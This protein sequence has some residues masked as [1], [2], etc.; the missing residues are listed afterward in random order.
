MKITRIEIENFRSI[1]KYDFLVKDF[2]VFVGQNNHGKT[3]LFDALDWFDSGKTDRANYRNHDAT[4]PIKVRVHFSQV[5][6]TLL[7]L[8]EGAYRTAIQ[9]VLH[10]HDSLIVEKTS[11][12]DKRALIIN[13]N[14]ITNPRGFDSALNYFLPKIVYV[15]TKHRLSDVASY[16][17]KS[18]IAEMLGDVL[19]DMVDHEPKYRDFLDLFN[20]LFNTST[21][22]FRKSVNDLQRRV[23]FYLSKQFAE[24][25]TVTFRIENPEVEDM[26]KKFET[27]VDDGVKTKAEEKGDGMQRAIMLAIVQAYADYRKEKGIARNFVFLIDEAELHLH[28][29]AQRSLKKALRDIVDNGG[30]VFINSHSSIFANEIFE[31]QKIF[32]VEKRAGVS[33]VSEIEGKQEQLDSIYQ[34]LGGSPSDILLPSNF[35]IVEG[36]SDYEFLKRIIMRFYGTNNKCQQIK[37]LFA[38][39]DIEREGELYH[40][41]HETY[42]PLLTNGIYKNKVVFLLD[43]PHPS[44]KTQY[45]E[46]K[47]SHPYLVEGEQIQILPVSALEMYYPEPYK[48]TE[49][50]VNGMT[51]VKVKVDLAKEVGDSITLQQ[52]KESMPMIVVTLDKA[53]ELAYE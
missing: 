39:G 28:P 45:E 42:K 22:I 26:L 20:D 47:K 33:C 24:G 5:Q 37:V 44:K 53:V 25:T 9:N 8:P 27:E 50:E 30:Q 38:N 4:L 19:V 48:K 16:K 23:E 1:E 6:E 18:P 36:K 11:E 14:R 31:N 29:T 40:R 46:F 17:A 52:L 21:S 12:D 51:Q 43:K 41:I 49:S 10:E 7:S 34:L 13:K 15:T 2:N 32:R 3:N 35:I